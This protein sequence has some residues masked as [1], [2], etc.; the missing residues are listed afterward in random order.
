MKESL[1]DLSGKIDGFTVGLLEIIAEVAESLSVPFFVVGARA[2][3]IILSQGHAIETGRATQDIDLGVQ[4]SDWDAYVQLRD[5]LIATA[6][7]HFD[8]NQNPGE[9]CTRYTVCV[10]TWIGASQNTLME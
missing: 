8:Y 6:L 3:D 5:A 1:F 2:R 7:P 4:V 9:A 10:P